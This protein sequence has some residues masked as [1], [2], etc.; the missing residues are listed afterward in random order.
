MKEI[1]TIKQKYINSALL[2]SKAL[3]EGDH[4][5]ANKH[6]R[7]LR[8]IHRDIAKGKISTNMLLELLSHDSIAVRASAAAELLREYGVGKAEH[9]LEEIAAMQTTGV[10]DGL[11][12][13]AAKWALRLWKEKQSQHPSN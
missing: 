10:E 3:A 8:N 11:R 5:T 7:I 4:K 2:N 6:G 12:V 1:E 9:V 13:N